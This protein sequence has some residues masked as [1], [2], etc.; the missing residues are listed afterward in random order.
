[1]IARESS[2][3][4][5]SLYAPGPL[6]PREAQ[7][8]AYRIM[9]DEFL[10]TVEEVEVQIPPKDRP[11]GKRRRVLCGRCG[12]GINYGRG[13]YVEGCPL[14]RACANG[15]YYLKREPVHALRGT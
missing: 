9:P 2:R 15:A 12:E 7:I 14:C 6:T 1:M 3:Q 8:I 13:V 10:F 4:F 5:A 11:G